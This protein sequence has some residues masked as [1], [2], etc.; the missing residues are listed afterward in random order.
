MD[1]TE[2]TGAPSS[3]R[4]GRKT[5]KGKK[6]SGGFLQRLK[7]VMDGLLGQLE[8]TLVTGMEEVPGE[9]N[10]TEWVNVACPAIV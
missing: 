9:R 1:K 6:K 5:G 4:P 8:T 3:A 7:P 2:D 10:E